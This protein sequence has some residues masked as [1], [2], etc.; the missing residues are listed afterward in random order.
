MALTFPIDLLTGFPGWSVS[1][2]PMFREDMSRTAAGR[3]IERDKGTP[4]WRGV[5]R[6]KELSPNRVDFWR[7]RLE[8]LQA[9]KGTFI[10][11]HM[12]RCYPIA[13]PGGAK[14]IAADSPSLILDFMNDFSF[15]GSS[16]P[17]SYPI[18][19]VSDGKMMTLGGF[20]PGY[21]LSVG[22]QISFTISTGERFLR[23]VVA[24][25][26]ADANGIIGPIEVRYFLPFGTIVGQIATVIKPWVPMSIV[27]G[28]V[29]TTSG[30]NGRAAISFE[31]ME[32][33]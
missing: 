15:V 16:V 8:T 20:P 31:G 25:A 17:F 12:G 14:I 6:S 9:S 5:Y 21:E 24:G 27:P 3:T 22:D 30:L 19:S 33:K 26:T 13:D 10:G 7:A 11:Y 2:E 18:L 1:F 4:L 29:G 32:A 28:S 23:R